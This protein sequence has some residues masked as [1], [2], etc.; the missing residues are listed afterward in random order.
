AFAVD[1][2]VTQCGADYIFLTAHTSG[3]FATDLAAGKWATVEEFAGDLAMGRWELR[4]VGLHT[5]NNDDIA[6]VPPR[7]TPGQVREYKAR[8]ATIWITRPFELVWSSTC[9]L[10]GL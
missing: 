1:D 3:V 6:V 8:H 5:Y 4:R 9:D 10:T 7:S 2:V